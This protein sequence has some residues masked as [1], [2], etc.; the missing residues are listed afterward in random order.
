MTILRV[1]RMEPNKNISRGFRAYA[2]MLERHPELAGKVRFLAFL[3]A[4][5]THVKQYQRYAEEVLSLA[6]EVNGALGKDG[7]KPVQVVEENDYAQAM[8]AMKCYDVLVVNPVIDGMSTIAKEGPIVNQREGVLVLS[9]T[10]GAYDQLKAGALGVSPA[11]LTGTA[12]ALYRALTMPQSERSQRALLLRQAVERED[13][14][15]WLT[16]QLEDIQALL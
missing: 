14:V 5:R 12:E 2:S 16:R 1:D 4:S 8:A 11:D 6:Q 3:V 9:E 10:S 7:W 13:Q 15:D